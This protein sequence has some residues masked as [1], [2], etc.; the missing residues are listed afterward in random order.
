M[1]GSLIISQ[2]SNNYFLLLG[3]LFIACIF[4]LL[5]RRAPNNL[6]A[7]SGLIAI[8]MSMFDPTGIGLLSCLFGG[9]LGLV[10]FYYPYIKGFVGAGDTKLFM[11]VGMYLGP[12]LA[13]WAFVLTCLVGG[14]VGLLFWIKWEGLKLIKFD[15][16]NRTLFEMNLPYSVAIL[17]GTIMAILNFQK[18]LLNA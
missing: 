10:I 7:I 13:L 3:A 2:I 6:I 11:L 16:T 4:D 18:I 15:D 8:F 5:V 17:L 14:F 12:V 9:I 1:I